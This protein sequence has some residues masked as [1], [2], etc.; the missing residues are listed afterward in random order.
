MQKVLVTG[1][2]GLLGSLLRERVGDRYDLRAL[3]RGDIPGVPTFR[4]NVGDLEAIAPA[5]E[6]I[7]IVVHLAGSMATDEYWPELLHTN[8]AGL[9]N[10]YEAARRAG[11]PRIIFAS[12]KSNVSN[13][14][15]EEPWKAI[16]E[17]RYRDV[18]VPWPIVGVDWPVR[19]ASLYACTKV[20]GEAI[21]RYYADA[22]SI[23]SICLRI[24]MVNVEDR[25]LNVPKDYPSWCS[26]RDCAQALELSLD[27][28]PEE[29]FTVLHV[30][31]R[32]N[33]GFRD[34]SHGKEV[35]GFE[36]ISEAGDP[37]LS[38]LA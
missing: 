20:W 9:Y 19:P 34:L 24:G 16:V 28:P 29:K 33:W 6:G 35:L 25:A 14:R 36:P 37:A 17:G 27:N 22:H 15:T 21:A 38:E 2:S 10:V 4:A 30:L 13:Y 18:P 7:D 12:S 26:Q 31:S 1:M 11:V 3:N 32:S 8:I 5:F 23:A